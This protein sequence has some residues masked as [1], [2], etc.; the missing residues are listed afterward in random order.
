MIIPLHLNR[1]LLRFNKALTYVVGSVIA[2]AEPSTLP[3]SVPNKSLFLQL[4]IATMK[5]LSITKSLN[6]F[7]IAF[8]L[9]SS[10]AYAALVIYPANGQS[11]EQQS[12]DE[13]ECYVW[14]KD[15][16]GFDPAQAESPATTQPTQSSSNA[17]RQV[18]GGALAG[19]AIG[20][21]VDDDAGKGAAIGAVGAGLFGGMKRRQ[22]QTQ[23]QQSQNQ[24]IQAYESRRAEYNTYLS[25]CLEGRGYSVK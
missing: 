11:A 1:S 6:T 16:T 15:K 14:A 19:A 18:L 20:E 3:N 23:Q 12:K 8:S 21:I 5:M 22:K 9:F 2:A 25:A 7:A 24:S 10:A 17:G 13:Y 4:C